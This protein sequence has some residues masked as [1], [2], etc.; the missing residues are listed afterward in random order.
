[1]ASIQNSLELAMALLKTVPQYGTKEVILVYGSLTST[2]PGDIHTTIES[3]KQEGIRVSVINLVAE[4]YV[5]KRIAEATGGDHRVV[6]DLD[7][8][9]AHFAAHVRPPP[10]PSSAKVVKAPTLVRMGFPR[11]IETSVPSFAFAGDQERFAAKS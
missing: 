8:L 1:M 9:R 10:T 4:I 3:L 7:S 11:R 2:D 5:C 6:L